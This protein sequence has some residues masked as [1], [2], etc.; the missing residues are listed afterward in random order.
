MVFNVSWP[1]LCLL[2]SILQGKPLQ[3]CE[4]IVI[5]ESSVVDAVQDVAIL[6][7]FHL[8]VLFILP[9]LHHPFLFPGLE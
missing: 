8:H 5:C 6:H 7:S 3:L 2:G 4:A 9:I 1:I